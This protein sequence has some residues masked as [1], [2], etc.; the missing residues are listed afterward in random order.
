MALLPL[1][2]AELRPPDDRPTTVTNQSIRTIAFAALLLVFVACGG[3]GP[4]ARSS[5]EIF[6]ITG[7]ALAGPVCPVER[8]PPDPS[9]APRPVAGAVVVVHDSSD[10]EVART[11]TGE[12]GSFRVGVPAGRYV[13]QA[14]PVVGLLGT[15]SPQPVTVGASTPA[16]VSFSYD[17]GI[18]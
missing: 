10:A 1:P 3:G 2:S 16:V 5:D 17:T 12:D 11:T 6:E 15:P 18:R 14:M 8:M 13:V 4:G 7:S 9:C